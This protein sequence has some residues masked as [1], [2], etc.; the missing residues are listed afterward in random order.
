MKKLVFV[1]IAVIMILFAAI[2]A[3]GRVNISHR[4]YE[5]DGWIY[6]IGGFFSPSMV[7]GEWRWDGSP[8]HMAIEIPDT[9][10]NKKITRLGGSENKSYLRSH[11]GISM[12]EEWGCLPYHAP[13]EERLPSP[14]KIIELDFTILIGKNLSE[15]G[16]VDCKT[17]PGFK[18]ESGEY[19]FY[20]PYVHITCSPE[21]KTFYSED[22]KLY[23]RKTGE[24]VDR[25]FYR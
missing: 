9:F 8:E 16:I 2:L 25:F 24:L 12:P 15:I 14:R 18:E 7:S 23:Y 22:G 6:F 17:Y 21:N 1:I 13:N 4:I 5:K 10:Q 19:I 11:F 3:F 20:K